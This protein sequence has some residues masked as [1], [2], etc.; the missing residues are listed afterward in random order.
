VIAET[1]TSDLTSGLAH[2][3]SVIIPT[4]NSGKTIGK[5]LSSLKNQTYKNIEIFVVDCFSSDATATIVSQFEDINFSVID[6]ERTIAKNFGISKSHGEFLLFL[7]SDM[8]LQ[9]RVIYN[10]VRVCLEDSR[11][12]GIIIPEHS[13]GDGF[14]VRVR[15]YERSMYTGTKIES[16]RF[17]RKKFVAQ[18]GG[19]DEDIVAYEEAILPFKI[20]GIGMNVNARITSYIFHIEEGFKIGAWL[21]KKRYYA[22]TAQTYLKRYRELASLQ[23]SVSYRLK[24]ILGNWKY[25][26]KHPVLS[27]GLF[28]LKL[29]EFFAF[30]RYHKICSVK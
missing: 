11:I 20:E 23:L 9:P 7:D 6:A 30:L 25:L 8:I 1:N 24:I 22:E 12:A 16:A 26:I 5:C 29:L 4:K 15:D 27:V 10:C 17:F 13:I 14:W 3:V 21:Q 19:F 28:I 2:R 18:V